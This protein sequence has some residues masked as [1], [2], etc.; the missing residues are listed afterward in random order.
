MADSEHQRDRQKQV[1]QR[2]QERRPAP[3]PA[4][5]G[6]RKKDEGQQAA[7]NDDDEHQAEGGFEDFVNAPG[8]VAKNGE[9]DDHGNGRGDQLRQNGHGE[10]ASLAGYSKTRLANLLEGVGVVLES[11]GASF[12]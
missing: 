7:K 8:A 9:A 6:A 2:A 11:P 1:D 3:E 10:R 4:S 12:S 5:A